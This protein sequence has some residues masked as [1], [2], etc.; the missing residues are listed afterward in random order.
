MHDLVLPSGPPIRFP[1]VYASKPVLNPAEARYFDL[2]QQFSQGRCQIFV[3]V[4]LADIV[5]PVTGSL[6]D[7]HRV[8]EK[9][10][11][12]LIC[13]NQDWVPMIGIDL[14]QPDVLRIASTKRHMDKQ[15]VFASI[16]LP[17]LH[18]PRDPS[19]MNP[20]LLVQQLTDAW[21]LRSYILATGRLPPVPRPPHQRPWR[22]S[23]APGPAHPSCPCCSG[24][25]G[26]YPSLLDVMSRA[27]LAGAPTPARP[28]SIPAWT[29]PR[30]STSPL[31][32]PPAC[33]PR[34]HAPLPP[35]A[36]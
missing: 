4:S 28:A 1:H 14:E 11:D 34:L 19:E 24:R 27:L 5:T 10:V 17:L 21:V 9:R 13:R 31:N 36:R 26:S 32:S 6:G 22:L 7:R 8:H 3:K 35:P 2:L 23:P 15:D 29:M 20:A 12:F 25:L 16:G 30:A 18:C 33:P